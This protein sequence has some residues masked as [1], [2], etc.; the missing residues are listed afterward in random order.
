MFKDAMFKF[1]AAA[2]SVLIAGKMKKLLAFL[3]LVLV[4]S[5][6]Y[7]RDRLYV[8]DPMAM[9]TRDGVAESGV[10]V[11]VNRRH[12]VLLEHDGAPRYVTL[13]Q[14]GQPVG[15]PKLLRCLHFV[16]CLT[17]TAVEPVLVSGGGARI[18]GM[19]GRSVAFRDPQG[20]EAVVKLY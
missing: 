13:M 18:E 16:A 11:F 15:T 4:A 7:S 20:R 6:I 10:Q 3:L 9:V 17:E 19:A 5:L 12:D 14:H 2:A 1:A 8:R